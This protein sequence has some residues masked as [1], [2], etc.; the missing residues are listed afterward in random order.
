MFVAMVM[1]ADNDLK[2]VALFMCVWLSIWT[3]GVIAL[4]TM[5]INFWKAVLKVKEPKRA[6][7]AGGALFMTLFALPFLFGELFGIGVHGELHLLRPPS[8]LWR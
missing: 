6:L 5:V 3:A 1:F 2:P 8:S 4:S 7:S